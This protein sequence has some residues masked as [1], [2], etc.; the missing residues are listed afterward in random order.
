MQAI[1]VGRFKSEFSTL[2]DLVRNQGQ[3]FV[4]EYGKNHKK[5]A[6]LVPY[7]EPNVKKREFGILRGKVVVPDDFD[8]ESSEI[9][10]MFYGKQS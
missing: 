9:D 6:M 2:L 1:Q 7:T 10:E 8:D 3:E 5:V 4:I